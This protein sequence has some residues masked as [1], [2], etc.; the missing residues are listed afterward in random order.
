MDVA[1]SDLGD[2]LEA[3]VIA[4]VALTNTAL[5][6]ARSGHELTFP[7]WRVLV[8]L[9]DPAGLPVA[10]VSRLID[11]T[12]PATGRQLRRLE[13]RGLVVLEPDDR[14]RRVTRV[15]LTS[16]GLAARRSIMGDRRAAIE[17][18]VAD[19][20]LDPGIVDGV[21]RIATALRAEAVPAILV[22][23]RA[24]SAPGR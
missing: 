15:R 23:R 1:E 17:R 8:V 9:A 10:E 16:A 22:S 7:Q 19:L 18:A 5:S 12:L 4:G 6:R 14:D 24:R 20:D 11:V 21:I 13:Q 2:A 3:I